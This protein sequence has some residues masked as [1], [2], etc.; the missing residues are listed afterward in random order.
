MGY[1]FDIGHTETRFRIVLCAMLMWG[2]CACAGTEEPSA[3]QVERCVLDIIKASESGFKL[4]RAGPV[5]IVGSPNYP[6]LYQGLFEKDLVRLAEGLARFD[7][8]DCAGVNLIAQVLEKKSMFIFLF[9]DRADVAAW[10][11]AK[12]KI[13]S[14]DFAMRSTVLKGRPDQFIGAYMSGIDFSDLLNPRLKRAAVL[15]AAGRMLIRQMAGD[16]D[17]GAIEYGFGSVCEAVVLG[18]PGVGAGPW[19]LPGD[20]TWAQVCRDRVA[21]KQLTAV[22][23]L[24]QIPE[25]GL[26]ANTAP[27]TWSFTGFLLGQPGGFPGFLASVCAGNKPEVAIAAAV[28][29]DKGVI[30]AQWEAFIAAQPDGAYGELLPDWKANS[31]FVKD[32]WHVQV[33]NY[34]A[35]IVQQTGVLYKTYSS[36]HASLICDEKISGIYLPE[37]SKLE[38]KLAVMFPGIIAA[39]LDPRTT[40]VLLLDGSDAL[41]RAAV[42]YTTACRIDQKWVDMIVTC[43]G[44]RNSCLCGSNIQRY[45]TDRDRQRNVIYNVGFM[46]MSQLSNDKAP[47]F[48]QCGFG[49]FCEALL[50]KDPGQVTIA[51]E[52]REMRGGGSWSNFMRDLIRT[53]KTD[54]LE[55]LCTFSMEQMTLTQYIQCWSFTDFLASRADAFETLIMVLGEGMPARKAI[56][57][58]YR[59]N[60]AQLEQN[61]HQHAMKRR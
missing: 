29:G 47:D 51:Y 49:N 26:N 45:Q 38:E 34:I 23:R 6:G 21:A 11:K 39:G 37:I 13:A 8:K 2:L 54:N 61:W 28:P 31:P 53:K 30:K 43:G 1:V 58:V 16:G 10:I 48:L 3:A 19:F 50:Y 24:I 12:D 15:N 5:V 35:G 27:E 52:I 42:A 56:P 44:W 41:R 40:C 18:H 32:E 57:L 25:N 33:Q 36:K 46:Y 7:V 4:F 22:N 9:E 60:E 59:L 55:A 14:K 20:K 17:T